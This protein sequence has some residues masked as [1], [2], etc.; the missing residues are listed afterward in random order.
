MISKA[1]GLPDD[2]KHD[3]AALALQGQSYIEADRM[4]AGT[5]ARHAVEGELPPAISMVSF[6]VST[7]PTGLEW[8]APPR[9][10]PQAPYYG[11]RAGVCVGAAGEW[12]EL[13]EA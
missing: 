9:V 3:L 1:H 13:I 12:I 11:R 4:P 7:W 10:L 2:S 8:I 6:T 5:L